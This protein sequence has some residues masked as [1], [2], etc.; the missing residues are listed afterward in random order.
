M[1]PW[2]QTYTTKSKLIWLQL[3]IEFFQNQT[4]PIPVQENT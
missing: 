1:N 3:K 2:Q 4:K